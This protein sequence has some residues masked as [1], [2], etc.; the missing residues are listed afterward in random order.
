MT[1]GWEQWWAGLRHETPVLKMSPNESPGLQ[2]GGG[3]GTAE[4]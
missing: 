2:Q 4:V 3:R 1:L